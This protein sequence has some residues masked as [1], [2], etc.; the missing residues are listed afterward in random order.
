MHHSDLFWSPPIERASPDKRDVRAEGTM[1]SA[2]IKT[3]ENA[4]G[5]RGPFRRSVVTVIQIAFCGSARDLGQPASLQ[6]W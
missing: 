6:E 5:G 3:D 1:N 2:A 4:E